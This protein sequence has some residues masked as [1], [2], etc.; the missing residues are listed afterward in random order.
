MT[1]TILSLIL[2]ACI[3]VGCTRPPEFPPHSLKVM[4]HMTQ[5][6]EVRYYVAEY[7]LCGCNYAGGVCQWGWGGIWGQQVDFK[8][9]EEA[10]KYKAKIE[11]ARKKVEEF[12]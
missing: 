2:A 9:P 10:E 1:K 8:T 6:A 11:A 12:Q 4:A 5:E 7:Q 3:L